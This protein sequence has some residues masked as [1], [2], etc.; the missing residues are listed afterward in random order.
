[1]MYSYEV[2]LV[3]RIDKIIGLFCKRGLYTRRYS[4]KE[5]YNLIDPTDRS[6]PICVT[7]IICVITRDTFYIS[8]ILFIEEDFIESHVADAYMLTSDCIHTSDCV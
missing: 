2:A 3:N 5:T 7:V 6:P 1:M 8:C 4:A